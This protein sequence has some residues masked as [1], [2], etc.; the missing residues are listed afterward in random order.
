M[1]VFADKAI[2]QVQIIKTMDQTQPFE[3]D[4]TIGMTG[5]GWELWQSMRKRSVPIRFFSQV[6]K[7][8]ETYYSLTEKQLAVVCAALQALQPITGKGKV[9]SEHCMPQV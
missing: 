1:F 3:L 4:V 6:W 9:L 8:A 5:F 7:E 2:G